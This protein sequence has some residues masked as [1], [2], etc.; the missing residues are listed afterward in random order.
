MILRRSAP[1]LKENSANAKIISGAAF[2]SILI[3][4]AFLYDRL[5]QKDI[6]A[7]FAINAVCIVAAHTT[8][9][10]LFAL[11]RMKTKK[12]IRRTVVFTLIGN[13]LAT[14]M[15]LLF[16]TVFFSGSPALASG[17]VL[18]LMTVEA[19][20]FLFFVLSGSR[21]F[22]KIV[23]V[24]VIV[25]LVF[26]GMALS[27]PETTIGPYLKAVTVKRVSDQKEWKLQYSSPADTDWE[28][29]E[30]S[31][32]EEHSL[33]LGNGYMG[34]NVFGRTDVERVQI[35]EK[36]LY[37][38]KGSGFQH[39]LDSFAEV[40]I[41]F[42]HKNAKKYSRD[43]SLDEATSHVSYV[44]KGV[45][46]VREYFTSYPDNVAVIRLTASKQGAL[47]FTLRPTVPYV[48]ENKIGKVTATGDTLTLSGQMLY[49]GTVFEGQFCIMHE[50][51]ELTADSDKNGENASL[52]LSSATQAD[53]LI[54]IGTNYEL[55]SSVFTQNDPSAKLSGNE[56][57]HKKVGET[58]EN[59][60]KLGYEALRKRH[61]EDYDELFS[62]VKID[63][64]GAMPNRTTEELLQMYRVKKTGFA[65]RYLEELY[66]QY[67]R[68]LLISSSRTGTLPANLQGAW[69]CH[70]GAPWGG[71]YFHNINVQMNYWPAFCCN[72]AECFEA[73]SAYNAA[74]MEAAK[75]NA[76]AYMAKLFPEKLDEAGKNGWIGAYVTTPYEI[77]QYNPIGNSSGPGFGA[78]T[79]MLFWDQYAFTGDKQLLRERI[80]PLLY[81]MAVFLDKNL[82]KEG[83]ALLCAYSASPEQEKVAGE[84]YQTVGCAFDQQLIYELFSE[85]VQAAEILGEGDSF[86]E[87]LKGE[88]DRL[89]PIL[90]GA[91]G[92]IKEY[93]EEEH[94]GEI[95]EYEHRHI[96]QLVGLFPG[97]S[98]NRNTPEYLAAAI[99]TLNKRGDDSTGWALA[100]RLCCRAR[101]GDGERTFKLLGVLLGEKTLDNLWDTHPP[102]QI[103]GNFGGTCG[104]AEM[105][106]QSSAGY[107]E[108]LPA[109]P[110]AWK[111]GSFSGLVARG[112]FVVDLQ[113]SDSRPQQAVVTARVGGECAI[114]LGKLSAKVHDGDGKEVPVDTSEGILRF[115]TQPGV[116]YTVEFK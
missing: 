50:D 107:I 104:I 13:V 9:S 74:Y 96:S 60:K 12:S 42:G 32:W 58:L 108:L 100:H 62:R 114:A 63:L 35:S 11:I 3:F 28:T 72:L 78:F 94:Y 17:I 99:V 77:P 65:A 75:M 27:L 18:S 8:L 49:Y 61:V 105:L 82:I 92:Q 43:L 54:A 48:G 91:D 24:T 90:V 26:S 116:E 14:V 10:F 102:F 59:A 44:S 73:Y 115:Q 6:V 23:C 66:F 70:N 93:R 64:G 68:Y 22:Y 95:G 21:A 40:Y 55:K 39:G 53:I 57:P 81:D 85:T 19:A 56:L 110:S 106:L 7:G 2:V 52:T 69:N 34:L 30:D 31:S 111:T 112:N 20:F 103:D 98:I 97:T 79:A 16:N 109:L 89:E 36:S 25:A 113:W 71:S 51:G 88:I 84:Y 87:K 83:D 37:N 101:T 4:Q 15:L 46:Y 80:Y 1:F 38:P 5:V 76:D 41:E 86:I 29:D 45:R 47:S 33:P 67:G